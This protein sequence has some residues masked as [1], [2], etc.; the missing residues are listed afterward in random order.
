MRGLNVTAATEK[1][2]GAGIKGGSGGGGRR[3][4]WHR[5]RAAGHLS[6]TSCR[7]RPCSL[8]PWTSLGF[9]TAWQPQHGP[10]SKVEDASPFP[11]HPQK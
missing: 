3:D 11:T 5:W 8:F 4:S 7:F 1:G 2:A 10:E 6:L 9:L